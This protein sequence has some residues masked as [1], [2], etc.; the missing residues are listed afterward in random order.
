MKI[1]V[2]DDNKESV[3]LL[4]RWLKKHDYEVVSAANGA[5]ALGKLH[6]EEF[7]LIISDVLMPVMDGFQFCKNVNLDEKLSSIPFIFYTAT[8]KDKEDKELALRSGADRFITKPTDMFEFM[9]IIESICKDRNTNRL[10]ARPNKQVLGD[11]DG[12]SKLYNEI[13]VKKLEHKMLRLEESEAKY[14]QLHATSFDGIIIADVEGRIT[15]VNKRAEQI[16]GFEA[17]K[18][19]GRELVEIIPAHFRRDH[20]TGMERFLKTGKSKIQGKVLELEGLHKSGR[21]FPIELTVNSF[22][23]NGET[24]STGTIRDITERK[25]IEDELAR[26]R[27]NL[28]ETVNVR[29]RELRLSLQKVQDASLLL[30]QANH[31]KNKFLS[32]MSHE[33]RTPLNAVLGFTD[34][35]YGQYFGK[36]NEKQMDYVKQVDTSGKHLLGLINNLLA[37]VKIDA[38]KMELELENCSPI[39]QINAIVSM[40]DSQFKR[41]KITVQTFVDSS[42]EV[43]IVDIHKYKQIMYNLLSNALK[44]TPEGGC[45]NIMC[46]E[47]EG[48]GIR[49]EISDTGIGIKDGEK[50]ELF[51]GFFQAD[52]VYNDQLGGTGA[53]LTLTRRLVE[54]HG[55]KLG[56]ESEVGKGSTFWFTLSSQC[57]RKESEKITA[58]ND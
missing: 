35:L 22:T 26:E 21:V 34:M 12:S 18:M 49:V 30:E 19:I 25:Q 47:E 4:E 43:M 32:S 51:S 53:G 41:K 50:N 40:M 29:T 36:L 15:E 39:E 57:V 55:G 1:L 17:G 3:R 24:Y 42:L 31:V 46:T 45:V 58:C 33:L 10:N 9:G 14:R 6:S 44:Y 5:E 27:D 28:E 20:C 2:V 38:G 7:D 16:F 8:Y 52:W 13:L 37:I 48:T 23:I 56:V 54:L 11:N